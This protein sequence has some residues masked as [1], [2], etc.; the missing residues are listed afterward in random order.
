V[1]I[2]A[3]KAE[4]FT[5]L[6]N[7]GL[8]GKVTKASNASFIKGRVANLS[9]GAQRLGVI[10]EIHP[11]VLVNFGVEAPC[12]AFEFEILADWVPKTGS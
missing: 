9:I 6:G 12:V 7:L 8:K 3:L 2:T 10:G 5:L 4:L 1:D 11:L